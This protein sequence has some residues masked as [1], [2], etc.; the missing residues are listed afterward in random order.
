[1]DVSVN[2]NTV[3]TGPAGYMTTNN[4]QPI[5]GSTAIYTDTA[6]VSSFG[7]D[8]SGVYTCSATVSSTSSFISD[9]SLS[10]GTARVTVG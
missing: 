5:V 10:R 2:V 1:M 6:M 9:S 4:A 3:W 8:Q 7:R